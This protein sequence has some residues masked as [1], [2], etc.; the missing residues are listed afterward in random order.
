MAPTAT[1]T[2]NTLSASADALDDDFELDNNLIAYDDGDDEDLDVGVVEGS[3]SSSSRVNGKRSKNAKAGP[4]SRSGPRVLKSISVEEED[5]F[6]LDDD[7]DVVM[8]N[9]EEEDSSNLEQE[10]DEYGLPVGRSSKRAR[11][12]E[13]SDT[14]RNAART[15]KGPSNHAPLSAEEKKR[16]RKEKQKEAKVRWIARR[17]DLTGIKSSLSVMAYPPA[18]TRPERRA[19][20]SITDIRWSSPALCPPPLLPP[21]P[22]PATEDESHRRGR[23]RDRDLLHCPSATGSSG[24]L[25]GRNAVASDAK[26]I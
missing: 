15:S 2:Q 25:H 11:L 17:A 26:A 10:V 23:S 14:Q 22:L 19:G 12:S 4:P 18:P 20:R 1:T 8:G 3:S 5:E 7:E 24:G 13:D 16:R 6:A 21:P 9:E